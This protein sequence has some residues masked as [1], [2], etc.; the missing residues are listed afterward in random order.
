MALEDNHKVP[1]TS[2]SSCD[3]YD[4]YNDND[5]Y[6]DDEQLDDESLS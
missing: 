6:D 1:F 3:D 2:H 5:D 4:D